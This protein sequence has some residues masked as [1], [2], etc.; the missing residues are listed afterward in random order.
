MAKKIENR[1][2]KLEE[3]NPRGRLIYPHCY[4]YG[5]EGCEPYWT[6]EPVK[7]WSSGAYYDE[8]EKERQGLAEWQIKQ[9]EKSSQN[10]TH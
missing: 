5:E 6:N 1:V 8:I 4:Y 9:K 7:T 10:L 2:Q 3:K